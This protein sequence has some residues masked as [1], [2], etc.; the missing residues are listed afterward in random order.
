MAF[1]NVKTSGSM[2]CCGD[3]GVALLPAD[4]LQAIT[5]L[6]WRP[7]RGCF[8]DARWQPLKLLLA[9]LAHRVGATAAAGAPAIPIEPIPGIN[10]VYGLAAPSCSSGTGSCSFAM[11][12]LAHL[13]RSAPHGQRQIAQDRL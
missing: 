11:P 10:A 9:A 2:S 5:S 12:A 4:A 3:P 8:K 13:Q 6:F 7:H 1:A